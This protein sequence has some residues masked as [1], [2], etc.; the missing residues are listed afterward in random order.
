MKSRGSNVRPELV[1]L[2]LIFLG[3]LVL[4]IIVVVK[5]WIYKVVEYD[6]WSHLQQKFVF[7]TEV[8]KA[9]RGNILSENNYTLV[10]SVPYY[11]VRW[12]SRVAYLTDEK[13]NNN[14][15]S[16]AVCL[17]KIFHKPASYFYKKLIR[18][19]ATGN[20]YM[21]IASKVKYSDLE[22]VKKCPVFRWGQYKGGLIVKTKETRELLFDYS[23]R[24]LGY[25]KADGTGIGLEDAF[26][27]YL[28][29]RDG[30]KLVQKITAD[31]YR[32]V[33]DAE[34]IE[35]QNGYDIRTTL[36]VEIEDIT[37]N[38]LLK[39]L[40]ET[41][42]DHGVAVVMEVK[43]GDIKAISN[44]GKVKDGVYAEKY[45]YAI[46]ELYEP[47][48][49]FKL[50]SMIVALDQGVVD[51]NDSVNTFNGTIKYYNHVMRDAH[52]GLGKISVLEAF[53]YSSNVGISQIINNNYKT[54]P[55]DFIDR[56]YGMHF[57]D[58]LNTGI[59]GEKRPVIHYPGDKYWSGISL[60]QISIGYEVK[61][62]PLHLLTFYNA[63]A[64]GGKMVKPRFVKAVLHHGKVVQEFEPQVI[65]PQICS[66]QTVKKAR[67]LL[68]AVV[69]FGTAHNI[70]NPFYKIAGKTGTARVA[71]KNEGYKDAYVA[72]FVGYFPADHPMYS[73]IVVVHKP[74]GKYYGSQVAA[75]VFK[76]IADKI[77]ATQFKMHRP[78]NLTDTVLVAGSLPIVK[79][80]NAEDIKNTL[81]ALKIKYNDKDLKGEWAV[82]FPRDSFIDLKNRFIVNNLMPNVK[83]MGLRDALFILNRLGLKVEVIGEG[84]VVYQSVNP[85]MKIKKGQE[86]ILKLM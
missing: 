25:K 57:N 64:N 15:D 82:T 45:N 79:Y 66:E 29:G 3:I 85:S 73:I 58:V 13:F 62:T 77:Y 71:N 48:S 1:K 27:K 70:K 24:T 55:E 41:D 18:A 72:S 44:L 31:Y 14:V 50:A 6:K 9:A 22:K 43:T 86:V 40:K 11:E 16:L 17:G 8:V 47:G 20:R 36:N 56:L 33:K 54:H 65:E 35:P 81:H 30:Q 53:A 2:L 59:K 75:P 37:H 38:S 60:P 51:L 76:E 5:V 28:R 7:K 34:N 83:G 39:M 42:A 78:I 74:K 67:K 49:T 52:A 80:G 68:E 21:L 69:Q 19:R 84:T 12:D 32:E 63:I 61:V 10:T 23:A 26:D 4:A 46:G